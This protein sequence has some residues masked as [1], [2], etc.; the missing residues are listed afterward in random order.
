M[1]FLFTMLRL[2]GRNRGVRRGLAPRTTFYQGA[3]PSSYF[4]YNKIYQSDSLRNFDN[5]QINIFLYN[6]PL[7]QSP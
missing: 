6:H 3:E 2:V 5:N 7:F 1:K 4:F